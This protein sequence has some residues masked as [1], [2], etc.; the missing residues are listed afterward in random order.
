MARSTL[1]PIKFTAAVPRT[2]TT[3]FI[4][5]DDWV[6]EELASDWKKLLRKITNFVR[7]QLKREPIRA[8]PDC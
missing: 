3:Q 1:A 8:T 2:S 5:V 6:V 7:G 4:E